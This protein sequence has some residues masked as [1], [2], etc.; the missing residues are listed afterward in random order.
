[1][2]ADLADIN[3]IYNYYVI[4]STCVWTAQRCSESE[5]QAWYAEHGQTMPVLVAAS[6]GRIVGWGALGSFRPAYTAAGTLEDSIYVHP[7]FHRRKIGSRLLAALIEAARRMGLRSILANI[8]A[9]QTPSI[10]LHKKFGFQQVA[11]LRQVGTKFDQ[12]FDAVYLQ[13]FLTA[14]TALSPTGTRRSVR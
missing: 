11:H 7:D 1:Q 9:D 12:W 14:N 4:H 10:R 5:R 13:L 3:A 2:P 6:H 8:S